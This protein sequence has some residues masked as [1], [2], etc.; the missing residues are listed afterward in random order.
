MHQA[1]RRRRRRRR[2]RRLAVRKHRAP[3]DAD[4][5]RKVH[6]AVVG[7]RMNN[8]FIR[9]TSQP[10]LLLRLSSTLSSFFCVQ[11]NGTAYSLRHME[12]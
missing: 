9:F 10:S 5:C 6:N 2:H 1:C 3:N 11:E 12:I 4:L 8:L 7:K